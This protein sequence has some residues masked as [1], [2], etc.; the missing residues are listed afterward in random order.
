MKAEG[1][2]FRSELENFF[3]LSFVEHNRE[4]ILVVMKFVHILIFSRRFPS[5]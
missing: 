3:I 4:I 5:K 2:E 1:E